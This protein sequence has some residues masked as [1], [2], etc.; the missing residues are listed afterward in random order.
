LNKSVLILVG[1][2]L[3][4]ALLLALPALIDHD[5]TE[6]ARR[7]KIDKLASEV[8][9][10]QDEIQQHKPVKPAKDKEKVKPTG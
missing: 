1:A 3:Y 2:E 10:L 8:R 6:R 7:Q 5:N 4:L 9:Q